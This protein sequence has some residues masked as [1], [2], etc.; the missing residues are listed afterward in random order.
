M[1]T[2]AGPR[3]SSDRRSVW[4]HPRAGLGLAR[5]MTNGNTVARSSAERF[6]H[7]SSTTAGS[8]SKAMT[9]RPGP[10][11]SCEYVPTLA[12]RSQTVVPPATPSIRST[13]ARFD[14]DPASL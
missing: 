8:W 7:S 3:W 13:M 9:W 1:T 14:A 10:A 5:S 2:S 11:A 6:R 12:P 4:A